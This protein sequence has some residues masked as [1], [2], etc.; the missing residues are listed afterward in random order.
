[1]ERLTTRK[2]YDDAKT[3]VEQL[4]A[5][6]TQKGMLEPDMDNVY[7]QEIALLSQQMAT[8]EDEYL[9]ILPL[10]Q[11]SPLIASIEDYFYAHGMKQ[12]V[13]IISALIH[14]PKL[15]VLDE[16]FVGLDPKATFTLKEIMHDM[17]KEGTAIFFSTH[18]LDVAEKLNASVLITV[19]R[20]IY[21]DALEEY[22]ERYDELTDPTSERYKTLDEYL[23]GLGEGWFTI[24]EATGE[25]T[26]KDLD[27]LVLNHIV[28]KKMC[29]SLDSYNYK[30]NENSAF[31][32]ADGNVSHFSDTV[33]NALKEIRADY[34]AD[35]SKLT[36]KDG[37]EF[38][39]ED[40]AYL[41]ALIGD[42]ETAGDP[43]DV[44]MLEVMSPINYVIG[45]EGFEATSA[46]HWRLRIGSEDGD[47]GAPAAWLIYK[48]LEKYQPD[49]DAQIG[50][51][52]SFGHEWSEHT[53]A[54]FFKYVAGIMEE[55]GLID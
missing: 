54:D 42:Y 46:A 19:P 18:V 28:R 44:Y 4:I 38:T 36:G 27:S 6:A 9:N 31:R 1:M 14:K 22:I 32:D 13:A 29:P 5:E 52:W 43:D 10:R 7:T 40:L 35:P 41:D 21:E 47:H 24:D 12:K 55:D 34:D 2:Q 3:R 48:A 16:P 23:A 20:E 50:I 8:Y 26:I 15:L 25:V 45:K 11:K 17:C 33:Y 49:I 37:G 30:S 39:E 53:K 51:C